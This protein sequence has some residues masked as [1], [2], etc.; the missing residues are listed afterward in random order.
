MPP[1]THVGLPKSGFM[2]NIR[3][4]SLRSTLVIIEFM[5]KD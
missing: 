4:W 5:I 2:L 3:P 1:K